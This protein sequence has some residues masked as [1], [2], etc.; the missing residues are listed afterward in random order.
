MFEEI[1]KRPINKIVVAIAVEA[2]GTQVFIEDKNNYLSS[3]HSFI[4]DYW[5]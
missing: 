5:K 2:D 3:L 1:T 4:E